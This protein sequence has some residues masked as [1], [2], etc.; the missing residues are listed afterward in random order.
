MLVLMHFRVWSSLG[1]LRGMVSDGSGHLVAI[2]WLI[3]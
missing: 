2:W 3:D 1:D